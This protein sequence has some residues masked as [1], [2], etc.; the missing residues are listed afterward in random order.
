MVDTLTLQDIKEF[1]A[2]LGST[3]ERIG[4]V[5]NESDL[6]GLEIWQRRLD[7]YTTIL[8]AIS[9]SNLLQQSYLGLY[10]IP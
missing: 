8:A 7:E 1:L 6:V 3:I 4:T 2:S 5:F 9:L 10:Q